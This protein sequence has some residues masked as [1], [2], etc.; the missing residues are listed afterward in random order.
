MKLRANACNYI[1]KENLAQVFSCEFCEISK[2]TFLTEQLRATTSEGFMTIWRHCKW[3]GKK[4]KL[5]IFKCIWKRKKVQR[6]SF[7]FLNLDITLLTTIITKN[8]PKKKD[9]NFVHVFFV[10]KVT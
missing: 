8:S 7:L 5:N 1:E 6:L 3:R 2:N 4:I 9:Q 10:L